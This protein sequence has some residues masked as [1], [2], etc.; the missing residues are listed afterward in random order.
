MRIKDEY[1]DSMRALYRY[2]KDMEWS[3][4][5]LDEF[6]LHYV[7]KPKLFVIKV[8]KLTGEIR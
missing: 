4:S 5:K 3:L 8:R 2:A 6:L 7:D 1:T